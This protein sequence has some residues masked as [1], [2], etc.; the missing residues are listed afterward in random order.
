M[1][2]RSHQVRLVLKG[3]ATTFVACPFRVESSVWAET[4]ITKCREE[5]CRPRELTQLVATLQ[6]LKAE[7]ESVARSRTDMRTART[8]EAV[9]RR[10]MMVLTAICLISLA[11]GWIF[12]KGNWLSHPAVLFFYVASM[13]CGGL[14]STMRAV[15]D[16]WSGAI[17]IDLLMICAAVGAA[18]VNEW[19]EGAL[20]LFLFSLSNTLEEYILGRTRGAIEALMDLSP[21]VASV[22]R[23]GTDGYVPVEELQVGDILIVRPGERIAADAV[24]E[25]GRTTVDQ[26][27][28][29]GES[30]PV[31]KEPGDSLLA[32]TLNQHGAIEVRVTQVAANSALARIVQLVEEAQ[33]EKAQSQRFTDWF[34]A[35]YTIAVLAA[36]ILVLAVPVVLFGAEFDAALYRAMTFLVVASPCAVVISIPAAIMSAIASAARGGVLFKG[37]SHLEQAARIRAIAFDKTGTLTVG[38]PRLVAIEVVDGGSRD[39]LLRLAASAEQLSEHPIASAV[40]EAA[41]ERAL[42]LE[43]AEDLQALVGRGLSARVGSRRIWVGR[44]LLFIENARSIPTAITEAANQLAGDGKTVLFVGDDVNVLGV[45]AVADDLRSSSAAAIAQLRALG[46]EQMA[47]LTGDHRLAA[48]AI[49]R[50]LGVAC[51]ADLLPDDKQ[52]VIRQLRERYGSVAMVGDGINDAPSLALADLGISL[53]NIGTDVALETADVVLM[54]DDLLQLPYAIALSR[55]AVRIIRQNLIFAFGVM[56]VLMIGTFAWKLPMP[57]AVVG[58]EGSTALVIL[59]GLRTL[60]FPRPRMPALG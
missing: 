4:S 9:R 58:H 50:R 59:N 37:G 36:A 32:G 30:L 11:V 5:N 52:R 1:S 42:L 54:A 48:D 23:N 26:S 10:R 35:R 27:A 53:G 56:V 49:A 25:I 29:T 6:V 33:S 47:I 44:A 45:I 19:P 46:V 7:P 2:C 21:A 24:V 8:L 40:V 18:F 20:L 34:G 13:V 38:R 17:N 14:Y 51:E 55:Q 43:P 39:E 41:E 12:D 22:R 3:H 15:R 31:D 28:L 16:L 60:A 57:L